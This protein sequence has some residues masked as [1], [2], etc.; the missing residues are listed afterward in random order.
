MSRY[1]RKKM[2]DTEG[3]VLG[4]GCYVLILAFNLVTGGW[5]VAQILT[6]RGKDIPFFWDMVIGFF[7]AEITT[8]IAVVGWIL[9][10]CGVF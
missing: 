8:P 3:N 5:G 7:T 1:Y 9:R 10:M 2:N 4:C 6:W